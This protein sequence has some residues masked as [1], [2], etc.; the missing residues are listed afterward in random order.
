MGG[1]N[2]YAGKACSHHV[3]FRVTGMEVGPNSSSAGF[4]PF[5]FVEATKCYV[6]YEFFSARR[7]SVTY[8]LVHVFLS[9]TKITRTGIIPIGGWGGLRAYRA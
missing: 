4:A 3:P 5:Y 6:S 7:T 8:V 2:R 9:S 1:Q